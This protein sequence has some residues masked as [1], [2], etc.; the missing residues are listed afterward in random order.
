MA[1]LFWTSPSVAVASPWQHRTLTTEN[2]NIH[3]SSW[4][5]TCNPKSERPWTHTWYRAATGIG[6]FA[7]L[8]LIIMDNDILWKNF[9]TLNVHFF[10]LSFFLCKV[11][12]CLIWHSKYPCR[13]ASRHDVNWAVP[14]LRLLIPEFPPSRPGSYPSPFHVGIGVDKVAK[15]QVCLWTL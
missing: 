10:F 15:V 3:A 5:G 12:E 6:T 13:K 8:N 4:I 7:S 2:K 11:V 14:M 9:I 1:G